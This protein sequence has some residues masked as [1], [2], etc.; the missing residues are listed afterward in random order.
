MNTKESVEKLLEARELLE[1][2]S[3]LVNEALHMSGM[4]ARG[5]GL[6]EALEHYASS[7]DDAGSLPNIVADISSANDDPC[8]TLPLTSVKYFNKKNI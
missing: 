5:K 7:L 6:L 2:V 1:Q 3:G 4:E 8:W